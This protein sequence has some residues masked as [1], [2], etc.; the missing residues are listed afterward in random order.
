MGCAPQGP[1]RVGCSAMIE[2]ISQPCFDICELRLASM[3]AA[4]ALLPLCS[5]KEQRQRYAEI[6]TQEVADTPEGVRSAWSTSSDWTL[7]K[8]GSLL[9]AGVWTQAVKG[10]QTHMQLGLLESDTRR[11]NPFHTQGKVS[12]FPRWDGRGGRTL[13]AYTE[14]RQDLAVNTQMT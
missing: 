10:L 8:T 1:P 4:S 14:L 3:A 11:E 2:T 12:G 5:E 13:Y 9:S 6:P 7:P